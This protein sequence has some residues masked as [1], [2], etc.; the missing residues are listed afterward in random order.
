MTGTTRRSAFR[1]AG[2][3]VAIAALATLRLSGGALAQ[4]ATPAPTD[5][6]ESL[7]V[8]MRT[9][10][11]KSDRSLDELTAGV[12][13]GLVPV[14]RAIPGFVEY[15]VVQNEETRERTGV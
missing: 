9:R 7:Y 12:L 6:K 3:G 4:N 14:I 10:T 2:G 8:V 11:V 15:Y 5:S 13:D 1:I